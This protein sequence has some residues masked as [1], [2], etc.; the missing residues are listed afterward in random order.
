MSTLP[1]MAS[2]KPRT[3]DDIAFE[4]TTY[5]DSIR[6]GLQAHSVKANERSSPQSVDS[7]HLLHAVS[8][9]QQ[10]IQSFV[11]SNITPASVV[12]FVIK[13]P[14]LIGVAVAVV[15]LTGPRRLFGWAAKAATIWKIASAIRG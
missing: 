5:R 7:R 13:R 4:L 8:V 10:Y 6:T 11:Q 15:A 9:A 3:P 2:T 14:I 1:T 12:Q